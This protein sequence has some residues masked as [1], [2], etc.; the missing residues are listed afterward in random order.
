MTTLKEKQLFESFQNKDYRDTFVE[1]NIGVG[2][3]YQIRALRDKY[4][5]TQEELA[6]KTGK[7]QETI[8]QWENPDYGSYT[9][10]TLRTLASAFDVALMINFVSFK[11]LIRR[12]SNLTPG[13]IAPPSYSEEQK[14]SFAHLQGNPRVWPDTSDESLNQVMARLQAQI[15]ESKAGVE[16][17]IA[18]IRDTID[19]EG[20]LPKKLGG[21]IVV[22]GA[23]E[24]YPY[25]AD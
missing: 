24:E 3:A 14:M 21:G 18:E 8:S 11:E 6:G 20:S 12:T 7:A 1:E 16:R 13:I 17:V 4:G 2:L 19:A 25:A 15:Q 5:W 9:L 10:K 23:D 22:A